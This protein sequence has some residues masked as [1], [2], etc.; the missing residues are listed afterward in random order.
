MNLSYEGKH[1][2]FKS[3]NELTLLFLIIDKHIHC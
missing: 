3:M 1:N 2:Q